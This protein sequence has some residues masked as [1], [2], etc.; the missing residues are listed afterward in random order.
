VR[1]SGLAMDTEKVYTA[2][3]SKRAS[4]GNVCVCRKHI[5]SS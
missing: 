3:E 2:A 5:L 4:G 1:S